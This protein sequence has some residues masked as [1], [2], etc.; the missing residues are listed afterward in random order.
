MLP[1]AADH[2]PAHLEDMIS[3][4][5]VRQL[6]VATD[7]INSTNLV[8]TLYRKGTMSFYEMDF[9][10][11]EWSCSTT[12]EGVTCIHGNYGARSIVVLS[13]ERVLDPKVPVTVEATTPSMI[14]T[15]TRHGDNKLSPAS[16]AGVIV[17]SVMGGLLLIGLVLAFVFCCLVGVRNNDAAPKMVDEPVTIVFTDIESSTALWAALPQLMPE[18]V[19]AHHRVIRLAISKHKCYEVKTIGDSF[20]IACKDA[21]SAVKLAAEIQTRL[22]EYDW[23]TSEID[24]AYRG[25]ELQ[26]AQEAGGEHPHSAQ[27]SRD[28]YEVLWSGL[29][30]RMGI[31]TGLSDIRLDEVTRGYDYYG[32]TSN[33]AARTEAI[34]NGGQVVLTEA[35]WW[36]LPDA[37]REQLDSTDL[38]AQRLRGVPHAVEMYQLN[39]LWAAST[40]TCERRSKRCCRTTPRRRRGPTPSTIRCRRTRTCRARLLLCPSCWRAASPPTRLRSASVSC[41]LCWRSGVCPSRH[42]TAGSPR[43]TTAKAS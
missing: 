1:D 18:A 24:E 29:R 36:A 14:Y 15:T 21:H 43:R 31:H 33:M 5:F 2:T 35:T 13:M 27:L 25:F 11:F 22:L 7:V 37:T 19:A 4:G 17:G 3:A 32:D 16:L 20:M 42:A 28:A 39:P 26:R 30:V 10:K 34:T 40:R 6:A 41:S 38:G 9:G 23:K 8:D 12:G